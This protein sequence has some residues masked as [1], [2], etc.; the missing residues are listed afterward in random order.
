MTDGPTPWRAAARAALTAAAAFAAVGWI[1]HTALAALHA[2]AELHPD[3]ARLTAAALLWSAGI[4]MQ[5][6]RWAA[7]LPEPRPAAPAAALAL[8]ASN[9]LTV[10]VPGPSGEALLATWAQR[11]HGVPWPTAAAAQIVARVLGLAVL[12]GCVLL[13]AAL[14]PG[15]DAWAVGAA[16]VVAGALA[17]LAA[18]LA[19]RGRAARA[20]GAVY[21]RLPERYRTPGAQR[22]L[23]ALQAALIPEVRPA[24]LRAAGWSMAGTL[25]M[26]LG[27]Y[28]SALAVHAAPAPGVYLWMHVATSLAG[29]AAFV[30]PSGAGAIDALWVAAYVA[31]GRTAAEGVLTAV[32]WRQMQ[33]VSL[34][35]GAGPL[36]W[37]GRRA[38]AP[39]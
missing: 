11:A 35:I 12:G 3:P 30:V 19:G 23:A 10:T 14:V 16:A 27:G 7:L 1:G 8:L 38:A 37:V 24:L 5:G 39:T 6:P 29:I 18:F 21:A 32:A 9:T 26:G 33:A 2:S 31:A 4:A 15:L 22:A 13:G 28:C 20:L 17:A 34:L 25:T 36:L